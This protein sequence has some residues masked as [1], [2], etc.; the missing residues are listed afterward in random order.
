MSI[1]PQYCF[2][3]LDNHK[4]RD[5]FENKDFFIQVFEG[6]GFSAS[7]L[8]FDKG[9]IMKALRLLWASKYYGIIILFSS[10]LLPSQGCMKLENVPLVWKPTTEYQR[11]FKVIVWPGLE[12]V[13]IRIPTFA[14]RR[15]N[16]QLIGENRESQSKIL[17]VVTK[18]NVPEFITAN[19]VNLLER[20]G[21]Q[22]I[23]ADKESDFIL[24]GEVKNFFV[25]ETNV[26]TGDVS[27]RVEL[28]N[29][30]GK[31]V[32]FGVTTGADRRF[33]RSYKLENY[34]EV[35]SDS[36]QEAVYKMVLND[37]FMKALRNE[38]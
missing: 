26:Y 11:K 28:I 13:T 10:L 3:F 17:P 12:K 22:V 29:K 38:K 36:L 5:I 7:S 23:D 19:I 9:G 1:I 27:L 15:K 16:P 37:S 34:Y 18:E 31:T 24:K 35:L 8:D 21:L 32:W 4:N 2:P 30:E 25:T 20:I 14:D 33:G 6:Q